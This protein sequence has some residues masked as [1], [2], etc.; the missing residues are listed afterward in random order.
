[1][2]LILGAF[3][4]VSVCVELPLKEKT[5]NIRTLERIAGVRCYQY[6]ISNFIFD[7]CFVYLVFTFM[8]I[9]FIFFC[10]FLYSIPF[11]ESNELRT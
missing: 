5:L 7:F 11:S 1:M 10:G 8:S 9:G 4:I 3:F 2:L 6:W